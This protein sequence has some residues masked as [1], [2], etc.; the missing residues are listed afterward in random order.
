MELTCIVCTWQLFATF[1]TTSASMSLAC[2][3]AAITEYI[4]GLGSIDSLATKGKLATV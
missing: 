2:L 4:H 3:P 1:A